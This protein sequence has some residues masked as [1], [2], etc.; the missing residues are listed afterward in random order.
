VTHTVTS[1]PDFINISGLITLS[2]EDVGTNYEVK[3]KGTTAPE[4]CPECGSVFF[5]KHGSADQSYMDTP[6]HGKRSL[7]EIARQRFKCQDC[8]KTFYEPL[9]CMDGKRQATKRLITYIEVRCMQETFVSL[10]REVGVDEKTVKHVFDDYVIRKKSE[11]QFKTPE[12]LGID[13]LKIIGDYR[14][15]LTDID[16]L[17]VFD[18]LQSRKKAKL[19]E[20]FADLP[21]K[22]RVHT[23]VMDMW[24]PYRQLGRE[25]FPKKLIVVDK[26]HVLRMANEGLER[27]RMRVRKSLDDKTRI[28]LKDDRFTLL[29]RKNKLTEEQKIKTSK[30]FSLFPELGVA[31]EAK[32]RFFDIYVQPSRAKAELLAEQWAASLPTE[33]S[34]DFRPLQVALGNWN[35][36][37]FN[38]YEQP[39]TNAYT[40]SVNGLTRVINRMGR[41]YSFEVLRAR[42]LYNEQAIAGAST[43]IR[44]KIRK[45]KPSSEPNAFSLGR[46]ITSSSEDEYEVTTTMHGAHL[47]TLIRLLE[48]GYFL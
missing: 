7:L 3:V 33:V 42:L 11:V 46:M 13:E 22:Q 12:I 8:N 37:I 31:Y 19:K 32:E 40:E 47:P 45:P 14:A 9:P 10:A 48:E 23:L 30:W 27:V 21:D 5:H 26:F 36:E 25:V 41:G 2:C 38:Y 34:K 39:V 17:G 6:M 35:R 29:K 24:N 44:K 15:M 20:Y 16:T 18:M 28:K 4:R 1:M 43:S